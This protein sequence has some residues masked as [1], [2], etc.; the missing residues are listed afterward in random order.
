MCGRFTITLEPGFWQEEFAL[1][2]TPSEWKPRYNVAPSQDVPVVTN[3]TEREIEM[4]RWG[5][6]PYWAKDESIGYKLIN[7]RSETIE[8]KPSYKYAFSKRRCLILADG[9]FEWQ[10][11]A[12]KQTPKV[13]YYFQ[14]RDEKPF[15]FA[16]IWEIWKNAQE[17]EVFSC[18]IITCPANEIVA[19]IHDRMPVLFNSSQ[20]WK[21]LEE[22]AQATLKAMLQPYPAE[23]M[24]TYP[25]GRW[26][27][28]PK[29]DSA[30]CI[31]PLVY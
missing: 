19:P 15:A 17:K 16:G 10:R 8:Q 18:S 4:M 27:N 31:L 3:A 11:A 23:E 9:F 7:A 6:I 30:E 1:K 22:E 24:K 25:V 13:P 12:R 26:I 20:C 2:N 21:W 14:L 5:L 28:N 29:N